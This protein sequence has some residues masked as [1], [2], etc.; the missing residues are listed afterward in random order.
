M[1]SRLAIAFDEL[2]ELCELAGDKRS[3]AIGMTGLVMNHTLNA[4]YAK[5]SELA[6]EHIE[7]LDS[8]DD[9]DLGT[10]CH[11]PRLPQN[12]KRRTRTKCCGWPSASSS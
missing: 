1:K 7:L 5:A 11:L 8:I 2:R 4:E 10:D 3:L 6:S 12:T 9:R